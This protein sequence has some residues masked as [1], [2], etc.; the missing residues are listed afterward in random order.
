LPSTKIFA[1]RDPT[2][3]TMLGDRVV[4][5][6]AGRIEQEGAPLTLFEKPATRF[7]AG[8]FGSPPMSFIPGTLARAE[9]G[10]TVRINGNA[11]AL[12][13]PPHRVPRDASDGQ[14]VIVGLRPEH[15]MRAVRASP[16]DGSLRHEAEIEI[17]QP[18]GARTYATFRLGGVP[19]VAE[20]QAFDASRPGERI[21]IDINLKRVMLFDALTDKAI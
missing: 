3:A 4:L 11:P 5:L 14:S 10:D 20:L 16:G 19:V 8:F 12:P 9:S 13:L 15:M 1:T 21:P 2:D 6:R 7:V 17:L 18:V